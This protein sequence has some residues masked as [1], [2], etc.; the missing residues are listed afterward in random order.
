MAD[1][2]NATTTASASGGGPRISNSLLDGLSNLTLLRQLGLMIGLAASVAIGVA[3]VMWSQDGDYRPLYGNMER[4]D[5]DKIMSTLEQNGIRFK[6]DQNSGALLV[7]SEQIH[8]ARLKLAQADLPGQHTMGFELLDKEQPLGTSQFMETTRYRRGLE[9]ELSRTVE[10]IQGVRSARVHLAIPKATTFVRDS[11]KP[12]ASV[13]LDLYPGHNIGVEQVRAVANLVAS[14]VPN[15]SLSDVTVVDQRGNLLSRFEDQQQYENATRQL[16]YARTVQEQMLAR[17]NSILKPLLGNGK[18]RAEVAA[19]VDFTEIEQADETYN[20]DAPAI[21]SEQ[22]LSE[23]K[24]PGETPAG[25]PG[26]LTN[27]PPAA[28]TAPEVA[29]AAA[30]PVAGAAPGTAPA[31]EGAQRA[32]ATRNYE[33]DRTVSYTKH[34]I[35]RVK[36]LTVAVAVDDVVKLDAQGKEA[37]TPWTPEE[38]E[39]L[40]ILVRDAVGFDPTRGDR[41][42]VINSPFVAE[43]EAAVDEGIAFWEQPW[44]ATLMRYLGAGAVL[45]VLLLGVLRPAIKNLS[46]IARD[47]EGKPLQGME[48]DLHLGGTGTVTLT[49][50]DS[51]L[52]PGPEESYEQQLNAIRGLIAEDPARVAQVVKKWVASGE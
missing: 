14:S 9:G 42:N 52:L 8:Q 23:K 48:G 46:A 2:A 27:Q 21:R 51:L 7:A 13:F 29:G 49:G 39:R 11:E 19:D 15:L 32:Q 41:V 40:S 31:A 36:R 30:A 20:P 10:S 6:L 35:G 25:V 37:R 26:A 34:P 18:F 47:I 17:I 44:F 1:A 4:M 3:V 22:T 5:A 50:G 45:L 38:L 28:G 16:N 33:L 24:A 43:V 12:S